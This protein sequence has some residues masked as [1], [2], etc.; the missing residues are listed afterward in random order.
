MKGKKF[1]AH[2]KHFDKLALRLRQENKLFNDDNLRLLTENF[3]LKNEVSRLKRDIEIYKEWNER[4]LEYTELTKEQ[5]K[6]KIELD[7]QKGRVFE[8][9]EFILKFF[10]SGGI[11]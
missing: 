8:N 2:K 7:K 9:M 11:L 4:L 6:E 1:D 5:I 3:D 10:N